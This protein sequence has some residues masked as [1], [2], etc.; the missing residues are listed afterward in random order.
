MAT[1]HTLIPSVTGILLF[2]LSYA[3][4]LI[5]MVSGGY[6][7]QKHTPGGGDGGHLEVSI[8]LRS[9]YHKPFICKKK[10]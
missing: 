8:K 3:M 10:Y 7:T 4:G 1:V 9:K 5:P 2:G 6:D